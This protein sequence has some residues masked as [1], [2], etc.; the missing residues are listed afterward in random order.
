[1]NL[2]DFNQSKY[3]A[4]KELP[5]GGLDL[6]IGGF[7][8]VKLQDGTS[9]PAM[10]WTNPAIKPMLLNKTNRMRLEVIFRTSQT[11]A[12][13]GQRV[14]VFFDRMVQGPN[15]DMVGG[16]RLRPAGQGIQQTQAGVQT[17]TPG[18]RPNPARQVAAG[19]QAV[20]GP[21][22]TDN[23]MKQPITQLDGGNW[24]DEVPF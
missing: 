3:L 20:P 11:E 6:V 9:K 23:P 8:I 15:G 5:E 19:F 12:L 14:G 16:L 17:F 22:V 21:L 13:I 4:G 7:D 2:Q 1:V 18:H 24:T 10:S